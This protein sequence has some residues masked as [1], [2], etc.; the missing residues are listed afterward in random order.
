MIQVLDWVFWTAVVGVVTCTLAGFITL[1]RRRISGPLFRA[2]LACMALVIIA[3][4]VKTVLTGEA[5]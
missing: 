3:L 2:Q 5:S 4:I 1:K